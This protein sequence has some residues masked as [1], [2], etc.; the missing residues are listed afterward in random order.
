M[1]GRTR[2]SETHARENARQLVLAAELEQADSGDHEHDADDLHPG[3]RF[4]EEHPTD[5]SDEC[6]PDGS[7][8]RVAD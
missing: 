6:H 8:D 3:Q 2:V 7:P 4:L 1:S 5:Q